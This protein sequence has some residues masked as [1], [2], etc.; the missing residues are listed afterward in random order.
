MSELDELRSVLK[1][2]NL[3]FKDELKQQE[4]AKKLRVSQSYV[5]RAIN[6]AQKEG[7]VK[8]SIIQPPGV[9]LDLELKIQRHYDLKQVI[10]VDTPTESSPAYTKSLVGSAAAHYLESILRK[11][12]IL[13]ISSWS[14]TISAMVDNM[15]FARSKV[16]EVVQLM[17]GVGN[18]GAFQATYLTQRLAN[19]LNASA[20]LLPAQ[21]IERSYEAK[22]K[23][24]QDPEIK[25]VFDTFPKIDIALVGIGQL[26]PS[27]LLQ[28][29][30]N[31]FDKKMLQTMV[32]DG[33]VGDIC[34]H[35]F[36]K[37]GKPVIE[38]SHDPVVAISLS[39]LKD[40]P[41]VIG[42]ACGKEKVAALDGALNGGYCDVLITDVNTARSLW[43]YF[44]TH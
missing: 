8:I 20:H 33:A 6:R 27:E 14:T 35:Y 36:D 17:G 37:R 42:L 34:L 13:G 1:I 21:S 4:I 2:A 7:F 26:E 15:H 30:G 40:V 16:K 10:V 11:N 29:S 12:D 19:L 23:I 9:H 44:Y 39:Q 32:D 5:S 3:Y 22:E 25:E 41:H 18:N 28:N 38:E 24:L 43:E 31:Y